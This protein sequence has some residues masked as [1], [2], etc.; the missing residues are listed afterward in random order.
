MHSGQVHC[1]K[2]PGLLAFQSV[3]PHDEHFRPPLMLARRS[4]L[5]APRLTILSASSASGGCGALASDVFQSLYPRY[6]DAARC[7]PRVI[8]SLHPQPRLRAPAQQGSDTNGH[9]RRKRPVTSHDLVQMLPRNSNPLSD[10][11]L[12]D[13]DVR[14]NIIDGL[15]G[16]GGAPGLVS[17]GLIFRHGA[18]LAILFKIHPV[19]V[20]STELECDAPRTIY[21]NRISLRL[22]PE[23]MKIV[24]GAVHFL[25]RGHAVERVKTDDD[26]LVHAGSYLC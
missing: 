17:A 23:W 20:S 16:M 1:Q 6:V 9:L 18:L 5:S 12:G 8:S 4:S 19:G 13:T 24:S 21:G 11:S 22:P 10:I 3:F 14:Q 15:T 25:G 2:G 26:A 7:M